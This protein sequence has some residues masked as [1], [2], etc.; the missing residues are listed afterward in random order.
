MG[1]V[2]KIARKSKPETFTAYKVDQPKPKREPSPIDWDQ[3]PL[4]F[5]LGLTVLLTAVIVI[6]AVGMAALV[7]IVHLKW[8]SLTIPVA[9]ASIIW[10]CYRIGKFITDPPPPTADR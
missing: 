1:N 2:G 7:A 9:L 4:L 5:L 6:G 8:W 10:V 3:A